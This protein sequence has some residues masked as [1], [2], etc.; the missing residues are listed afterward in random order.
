MW[1]REIAPLGLVITAT[2]RVVSI[3]QESRMDPHSRDHQ[4]VKVLEDLH[5]A[6][7][8][9]D[10]VIAWAQVIAT[11]SSAGRSPHATK[12][13]GTPPG[14]SLVKPDEDPRAVWPVKAAALIDTAHEGKLHRQH[15]LIGDVST[16][17][18][19]EQWALV[20]RLRELLLQ[21][22]GDGGR[23]TADLTAAAAAGDTDRYTALVDDLIARDRLLGLVQ[24]WT[25]IA[26][27][28]V[29]AATDIVPVESCLHSYVQETVVD[30]QL[31]ALA[32][33]VTVLQTATREQLLEDVYPLARHVYE[34]MDAI[35]G[36]RHLIAAL[37]IHA[38]HFRAEEG[39]WCRRAATI[40]AA[41]A[42][43][44]HAQAQAYLDSLIRVGGRPALM[45][46]AGA[47]M[48]ILAE[49]LH[50]L[51]RVTLAVVDPHGVPTGMVDGL[52]RLDPSREEQ[53]VLSRL[54]DAA[55]R[56]RTGVPGALD[57]LGPAIAGATED[58]MAA[59]IQLAL[60][61]GHIVRTAP[62]DRG[63]DSL[64]TTR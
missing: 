59:V 24:W 1:E 42:S 26:A 43:D 54:R 40:T 21:P 29:A 23:D 16:L 48:D 8:T 33:F 18:G 12:P 63:P 46:V 55:M 11:L 64:V 30:G 52:H 14:V 37:V 41:A 19:P 34:V 51:D 53:H 32:A 22:L 13:G 36:R 60:L 3:A 45:S 25:A 9:W 4:I 17:A 6:G 56:I 38:P 2:R 31:E 47:W 62:K 35:G 5:R 10:A 61:V 44:H 27:S 28:T 20:W 50:Y 15:P 58:G 39:G 49:R 7:G 57:D